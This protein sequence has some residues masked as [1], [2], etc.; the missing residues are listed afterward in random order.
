MHLIHKASFDQ[1]HTNFSSFPSTLE[2][3]PASFRAL[4]LA[5][6][7][8]AAVSLL[9][10]QSQLQLG[11]SKQDELVAKLA[12]ATEKALIDADYMKSVKL[13]TLQAFTIY[14]VRR[15]LLCVRI[16]P[17]VPQMARYR[18][19]VPRSHTFLVD[20]LIRLAQCAGLHQESQDSAISPVERQTRRLLWH[21]ICFIDLCTAKAR[22]TQPAIRDDDFDTALPLNADDIS[23]NASAKQAP[24]GGRWTDT[25]FT[26]IR[27]ECYLVYRAIFSKRQET[28]VE[29]TDLKSL[30]HWVEKRKT[31]IEERYLNYLNERIPIQQCAKIVGRLLTAR[32]N[33]LLFERNMQEGQTSAS[34]SELRDL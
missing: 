10:I 27:Y 18:P 15:V 1:E 4:L 29:T 5:L 13:Q 14:M 3:A 24:F 20:V 6:C 2:V 12:A 16:L 33:V 28:Y 22:G 21:Q 32:F 31:A 34:Q 19:E 8:S 25:M 17:N 11:I 7:L 23:F 30:R 9:P 26:L